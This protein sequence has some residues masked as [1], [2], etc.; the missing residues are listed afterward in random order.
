MVTVGQIYYNVLDTNS[1]SYIS[2]SNIDIF[3]DVVAA[4]G[5]NQFNKLGIQAPPGTKVVMNST[6]TIMVGRTGMYELDHDINIVNMYFVRPKK[7]IKDEVTS[8]SLIEQGTQEMQAAD[9][10]RTQD[11][12][13]L[14]AAYPNGIPS[15]E[16][17][18]DGY[19]AYWTAYNNIQAKY[20]SA[21]QAGLDK[22]NRGV[23]GVYILPNP[24]NVDA[25]ENY[26]DLFNI[27]VDF[28]YE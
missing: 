22:Y 19:T 3:S 15:Q 28:I 14:E 2:S 27:I 4:Y 13:D 24:N 7:Y 23:N 11:M 16:N 18:P 20:I 17:D 9:A 21:Y 10:A 5:A 26:Q 25:E 6:K 1:G 8:Q 12:N